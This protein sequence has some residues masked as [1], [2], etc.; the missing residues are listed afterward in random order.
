MASEKTIIIQ[1]HGYEYVL[2]EVVRPNYWGDD[3]PQPC[4]MGRPNTAL[5]ACNKIGEKKKKKR[6]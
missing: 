5:R 3:I 4:F 6:K 1:S 2:V